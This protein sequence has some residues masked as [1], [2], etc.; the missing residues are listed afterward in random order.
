MGYHRCMFHVLP[1]S[2]LFKRIFTSA[3]SGMQVPDGTLTNRQL[4]GRGVLEGKQSLHLK[5][6]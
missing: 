1:L 3:V 5:F 6:K 4:L 2:C